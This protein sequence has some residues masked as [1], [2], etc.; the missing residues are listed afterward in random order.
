MG[1]PVGPAQELLSP[2]SVN[3]QSQPAGD[4][5]CP[6]RQPIPLGIQKLLGH[7]IHVV[8]RSD[9]CSGCEVLHTEQ[10]EQ[11]P[12]VPGFLELLRLMGIVGLTREV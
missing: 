8:V 12:Q 2:F 5:S 1:P 11:G 6:F 7:G 10:G 9:L 3:R 4:L